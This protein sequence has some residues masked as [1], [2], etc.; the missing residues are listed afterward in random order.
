M[1]LGKIL[2]L[3]LIVGATVSVAHA[4]VYSQNIVGHINQS[5]SIGDNLIANQLSNSNNTLNAIF[6]PGSV[7]E[8]T[9]A[10]SILLPHSRTHS[11]AAFG[12]VSTRLITP[13]F[14][15]W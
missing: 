5:F 9:T 2:A 15:P 3:P 4:Q 7:P 12:R 11:L 13:S 8:G 1:K 14:R 6:S 10:F